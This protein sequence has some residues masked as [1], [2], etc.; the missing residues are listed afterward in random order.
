[1][2]PP[3]S[4]ADLT[5]AQ[6]AVQA[7]MFAIFER[8]VSG[9]GKGQVIDVSLYEP[10]FRLF[11]GDVEAYDRLGEQRERTGNRHP[12]A[13]PRNVYETADGHITLS[14]SSQHIFENV[15]HA[16][17]RPDLIHDPRF[18]TNDDRVDNATELDALIEEWTSERTTE[19]AISEMEAADAIVGPIYDMGDIFE[20]DQYEARDDIIEIEDD[21]LGTLR[22]ANT[23]PKFSRTP[24]GVDHAGP[25]HGQHN[26]EVYLD[27]LGLHRTTYERL[28]KGGII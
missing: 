18:A 1:M 25:R 9:S 15:M 5:A 22:T 17:D 8:D 19:Q 21:E 16:I 6:F 28:R 26:E 24:G 13:A 12:S 2:L 4:L 20:D 10:L 3:I 27:E 23:V 11:L 7:A 14:A